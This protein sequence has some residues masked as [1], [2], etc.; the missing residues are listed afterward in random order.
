V[1]L[2]AFVPDQPE[3]TVVFDP[4]A[5]RFTI[6]DDQPESCD[7]LLTFPRSGAGLRTFPT[8]VVDGHLSIDLQDR[9][10]RD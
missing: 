7:R 4:D 6:G 10:A 1:A 2:S 9:T 5:G 3:C 8:Q